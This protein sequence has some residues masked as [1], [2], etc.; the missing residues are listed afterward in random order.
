MRRQIE[1]PRLFPRAAVL[2]RP[3]HL[4]GKVSL[5]VRAQSE[6]GFDKAKLQNGI[7]EPLRE[8]D[9]IE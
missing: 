7:M 4:A 1:P 3:Q 6:M 2:N 8:A 9:L 5:T